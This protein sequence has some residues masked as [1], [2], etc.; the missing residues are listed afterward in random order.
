METIEREKRVMFADQSV[1]DGLE[2]PSEAFVRKMR[3]KK[4]ISVEMVVR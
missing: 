1:K 3:S 4:K 2:T